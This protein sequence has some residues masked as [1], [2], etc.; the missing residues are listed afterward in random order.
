MRLFLMLNNYFHDMA[1]AIAAVAGVTIFLLAIIVQRKD[2][3]IQRMTVSVYPQINW[4]LIWTNLFV[5]VT[6]FVRL[7]NFKAFEWT[8]AIENGQVKAL[9]IK[10]TILIGLFSGGIILWLLSGRKIRLM[11][12]QM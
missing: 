10:H 5:L 6:G 8:N 7:Q 1:V 3:E 2:R 4:F 9:I 12:Q 11:R